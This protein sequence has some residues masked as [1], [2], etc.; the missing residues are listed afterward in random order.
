[1]ADGLYYSG[2]EIF[3]TLEKNSSIGR[4]NISW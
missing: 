2:F 1:M 4:K 3:G